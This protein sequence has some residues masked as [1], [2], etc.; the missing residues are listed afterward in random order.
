MTS[1]SST[2]PTENPQDLFFTKLRALHPDAELK[3][4]IVRVEKEMAGGARADD[5]LAKFARTHRTRVIKLNKKT[6]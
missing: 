1:V 2:T 4:I 3:N 5:R 6:F